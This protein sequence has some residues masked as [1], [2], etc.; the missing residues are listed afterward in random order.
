MQKLNWQYKTDLEKAGLKVAKLLQTQ[1]FQA[2]WVGGVVRN[3]LLKRESDN[4]DIATDATPEQIEKILDKA[5]IK[6]KPVGKQFGSILAIVDGFKIELTTFRAEGR[7]SDKRHPDQVEFIRDYL[8]DA[9]RRDFTIN[10]LYLDP[11]KKMLY[12]PTGGI[13]D[14]RLRLLRF[15]GDPKKRIDEDAL[16]MLR[17]VRLATQ[18]GFKLER[19]S[20][21]AIKTRAKYIQG[22]SGERI[23]AE[24]D[25]I[26]LAR[27]RVAGLRLLDEIGLLS[28]IIP[29]LGQLKGFTHESRK[30]HLEGDM[31]EHTLLSLSQ[32]PANNLNLS[33]SVIF[34]DVGKPATAQ[35]R[36]KAE[37]WVVSTHGHAD[38][39]A[40]I[41]RE[42][43]KRLHFPSKDASLIE[44]GIRNHMTIT[45][46]YEMRDTTKV[47]YVL[48]PNFDFL[49]ELG[50]LDDLGTK[51]SSDA[52][53]THKQGW[54]LAQR[55]LRQVQR[56]QPR[57]Q[58]LAKGDL[59]MKYSN[60]KPGRELGRKIQNVKT[61]IVLGKIKSVNDLQIYLKNP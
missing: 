47:K 39:S 36:L 52:A 20:F 29:E 21:A 43:A 18:L 37:G 54:K 12:D 23:K 61:Q 13:K 14:L 9:K 6:N 58:K 4:I 31:F 28:F 17:G 33:Y 41:F 59:I 49:V 46:F 50:R 42:F 26:L 24:L 56:V 51:R 16:R 53:R 5:K 35:K 11:V 15:V 27:N 34:H 38:V 48:Q 55:W 30:Y 57:L 25:K 7:Y 19:N 60:L 22:I 10:A 40:D 1:K 3:M 44:W 2:F 45:H 32:V 8:Q